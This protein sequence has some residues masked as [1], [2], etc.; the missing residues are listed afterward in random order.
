MVERYEVIE[1]S[2]PA[3]AIEKSEYDVGCWCQIVSMTATANSDST[4]TVF[5]KMGPPVKRGT[6]APMVSP[7]VVFQQ[8]IAEMNRVFETGSNDTPTFLNTK[9]IWEFNHILKEEINELLEIEE[10]TPEKDAMVALA[11][12][13]GD[14]VVYCFSEAKRWGIPLDKVLHIIMDSQES[15]LVDGKPIYNAGRTKFTKGPHYVAPEPDIANL[16]FQNERRKRAE[17]DGV[18]AVA[19]ITRPASAE[20]IV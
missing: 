13:L 9:R 10:D 5:S 8:R 14:I 7:L 11:D 1:A 4:Y 6:T 12:T 15:K 20:P 2:S 17:D 19:P 3:E 18:H 16:L